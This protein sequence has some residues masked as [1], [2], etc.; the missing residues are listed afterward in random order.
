MNE[1]TAMDAV[2]YVLVLTLPLSALFARRLPLSDVL[3][4]AL[5]W[6]AIFSVLIVIVGQRER[7]RPLWDGAVAT[8]T[9]N[10]QNVSG[11]TVRIAMASDGHFYAAVRINGIARTMLID[12]G[13]TSTAISVRTARACGIAF[14]PTVPGVALDTANGRVIAARGRIGEFQVGDIT[15]HDL[16]VVVADTFGDTDL[17]GMNFLSRLRG[18]RVEGRTLVLEPQEP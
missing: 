10:R 18:W 16:P 5:A 3:K 11:G 4:M 12:S 6:I 8:V 17:I 1:A 9:G 13:A 7:F 14:D 2:M 15:A